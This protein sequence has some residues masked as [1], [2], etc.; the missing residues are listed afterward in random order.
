MAEIVVPGVNNKIIIKSHV[1]NISISGCNNTI[2]GLDPNCLINYI[3]VTGVGNTIDLNENCSNVR[4]CLSGL[5]NKIKING[6]EINDN[7]NN[8][9]WFA[10]TNF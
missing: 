6:N 2:D 8:G 10:F 7:N 3:A 4:R 1:Q 9:Y 5:N